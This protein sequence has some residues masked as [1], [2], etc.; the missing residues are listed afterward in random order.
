MVF[1]I[2][3]RSTERKWCWEH[4]QAQAPYEGLELFLGALRP[5]D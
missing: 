3:P 1:N 2:S 4:Q 5:V